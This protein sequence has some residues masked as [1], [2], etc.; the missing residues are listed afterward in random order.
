MILTR[1]QAARLRNID[2]VCIELGREDNYFLGPNGAGKTSILEAVYFLGRGRSFRTHRSAGLVQDGSQQFEVVGHTSWAGHEVVLGVRSGSGGTEARIGGAPAGSL[3]ELAER[4]PVQ[5][6]DPETHK[7]VEEGPGHRRRFLDWGVFQTAH[8]FLG[9]WR[10]HQRALR[11]RNAALRQGAAPEQLE[12]WDRELIVAAQQI[13]ALREAYVVRLQQHARTTVQAL[14]RLPVALEYARGW[15]ADQELEAALAGS[16][17]RDRETGR[18]HYGPHRADLRIRVERRL[19]RG[20][21]S[22]GQQK[23]LAA[24]LVLAQLELL[25]E[26]TGR[27]GILLLDDPAAELDPAS[28]ERLLARTAEMGVQRLITGL[29]EHGLAPGSDAKRFAIKAGRVSELV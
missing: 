23:L 27:R 9:S 22:R 18:T 20:R 14:L 7:L 1:L 8:G 6:I 16:Q 11:Q 13:T 28:L 29:D 2:A 15:P 26:A 17:A 5:V 19:A 24:A 3:A 21:V 25:R 10:N 4:L 12:H